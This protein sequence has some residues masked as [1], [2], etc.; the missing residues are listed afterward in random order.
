MRREGITLLSLGRPGADRC[1]NAAADI[2][3]RWQL[4]MESHQLSKRFLRDSAESC[5]EKRRASKAR[6]QHVRED[7]A[8]P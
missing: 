7:A 1:N 4:S 5:S 2:D 3:Y 6:A 8:P